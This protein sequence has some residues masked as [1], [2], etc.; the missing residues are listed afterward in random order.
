MSSYYMDSTGAG[1][2]HY[3]IWEPEGE[4][5]AVVQIVHGIAEHIGRYDD[6]ARFLNAHGI[7]VAAADHM[8][9]GKSIG[10][11]DVKGYFTGGWDAAVRDCRRLQRRMLQAYPDVPHVILGHSMGSFLVRTMLYQ[12]PDSS[13][14]GAILS[15]T[16]WQPEAMLQ[17]GLLACR[18][19]EKKSGEKA[20]SD[21]LNKLIFGGYNTKFRPNRTP[22]DWLSTDESVVDHYIADPLCGFDATIGLIRDMLTGITMN[23]KSENL[24]KMRKKLPVWFFSGDRDP[25]GGNGAGVKKSVD[26]FRKA[27]MENVKMT[28]YSGRHEMLN[29]KNKNEVY[30]D[31]LAW[32]NDLAD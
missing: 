28:L 4:P 2:I 9:H 6:F 3:R 21:F 7:V 25:V 11:D 10:E 26:A 13:V 1:R 16:G 31:V 14:T 8:G 24:V 20:T 27:G 15:G 32:I 18:A 17:A 19:A 29:E 30:A 23:Q 22:S 5:C 12:Y